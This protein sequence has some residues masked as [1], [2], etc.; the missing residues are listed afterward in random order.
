VTR[1]PLRLQRY[2]VL[3]FVT[4]AIVALLVAMPALERVLVYPQTDF[5]TALWLLGPGHIGEDYPFNL[6]SG[7][8]Y[9]VFLGIENHLGECGYYVI[10]VK[11]RNETL[12]APNTFNRTPSRLSSLYNMTIFV[13]DT[14]TWEQHLTFR[15]DYGYGANLS[16]VEFRN[17][18]LNG[19]TLN[20]EGLASDWN[21]TTSKFYGNLIFELWLYNSSTNLFEYNN[22]FVDLKFNMTST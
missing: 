7:K 2:K 15:L 16:T 18:N 11:F 19:V 20:L 3:F 17:I 6:T 22:R 10:E 1:M 8:D 4:V 12:S 14:Q 9:S 13:P 5:Y 21:A